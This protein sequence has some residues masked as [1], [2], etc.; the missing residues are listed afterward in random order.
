MAN[1]QYLDL[2]FPGKSINDPVLAYDEFADS[3]DVEFGND[4]PHAREIFEQK[5]PV[6]DFFRNRLGSFV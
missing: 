6:D 4:A 5:N 1:R 2:S 3:F